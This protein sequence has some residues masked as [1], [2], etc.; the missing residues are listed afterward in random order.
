[1]VNAN[2]LTKA[3]LFLFSFNTL[4]AAAICTML[5]RVVVLVTSILFC[6][7]YSL[8]NVEIAFPHDLP[9]V[10]ATAFAYE[11]WILATTINQ[12]IKDAKKN[13]PKALIL[14]TLVVII[15]YIVYYIGI[16]HVCAKTSMRLD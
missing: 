1:M 5:V 2:A 4:R 3:V 6:F 15:A 16:A 14:G 7:L 9:A 10:V 8:Y 11:G 13:L 12:E